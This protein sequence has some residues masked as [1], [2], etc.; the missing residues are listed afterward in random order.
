MNKSIQ[1]FDIKP[2]NIIYYFYAKWCNACRNATPKVEKLKKEFKEFEFKE[3]DTDQNKD[4]VEKY[5]ITSIPSF[6]I[7]S[8]KN[9]KEYKKTNLDGLKNEMKQ[10]LERRK[11]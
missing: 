9:P 3:I 11:A 5:N 8:E 2:K 7:F 4:L 1:S 6:I 10:I